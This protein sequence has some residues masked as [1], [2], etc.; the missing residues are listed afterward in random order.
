M[1]K[2]SIIMP[3]YNQADFIE[4]S[5][6]SVLNQ[7]YTQFELI[8]I[9]GGSSDGTIY[10]LDKYRSYCSHII[11]EQDRGQS[12]ALNKGFELATG[13]V[14]G[15]LNSDDI[16]NLEALSIA[17]SLFANNHTA[18]VI[19]G[20][21]NEIDENDNI[22]QRRFSFDFSTHHHAYE[23]FHCNTQ[24]MFWRRAA[25]K[26]FGNFDIK[27]HRTMDYEMLLV[28]GKNEGDK[29]FIRTDNVIGNFRQHDDQK[30]Q[31]L[32]SKVLWEHNYI[33]Q[34][35]GFFTRSSW[36]CRLIRFWFRLRRLKWYLKRGG[37]SYAI[38]KFYDSAAVSR[39]ATI[40][41]RS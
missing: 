32:D 12:D 2:F 8:I 21:W 38:R 33:L 30:T 11:I 9:D 36:Q 14:F 4:R 25:H 17:A 6:I 29:S 20:D 23:G 7:N 5:I 22:I 35:H 24:S 41:E 1:V 18:R 40:F 39:I 15:W 34:K 37:L 13:D 3:S 27:L 26:R 19:F 16:Y 28:L 31:G 10:I